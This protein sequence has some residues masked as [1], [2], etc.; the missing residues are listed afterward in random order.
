[1][2]GWPRSLSASTAA[3]F[4]CQSPRDPCNFLSR[5]PRRGFN[6]PLSQPVVSSLRS[7]LHS[8]TYYCQFTPTILTM[9]LRGSH[10]FECPPR[11][12][13]QTH[14]SAWYFLTF[15]RE[16]EDLPT[17]R[18]AYLHRF[19][20]SKRIDG[21]KRKRHP[22]RE[23]SSYPI[24]SSICTLITRISGK[25][26]G[27]LTD[28][29]IVPFYMHLSLSLSLSRAFCARTARLFARVDLVSLMILSSFTTQYVPGNGLRRG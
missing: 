8:G 7:G 25:L 13:R 3:S 5:I 10:P 2:Q 4:F 22:G 29:T 9:N 1:M 27:A 14:V 15:G 23:T 24:R 18:R 28:W 12:C 26:H 20:E 21:R 16:V 11:K 6:A 17:Y 19:I